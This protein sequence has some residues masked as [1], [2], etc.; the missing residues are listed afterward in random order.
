MTID[1]QI[2]NTALLNFLK[3]IT[4][5]F[6][7]ITHHWAIHRNAL[8]ATV[9]ERELYEARTD[10]YLSGNS[11]SSIRALVE[12]KAAVRSKKVDEIFMQESAQMVAW[13]LNQPEEYLKMPGRYVRCSS[14]LQY[15]ELTDE[16]FFQV[17]QDRHEIYLNFA[18]FGDKYVQYL[19]DEGVQLRD[20]DPES[21]MTIFEV[22]PYKTRD[23]D[24][25]MEL[26]RILLALT[27]RADE[28]EANR[29]QR[30][31]QRGLQRNLI[32]EFQRVDL[33]AH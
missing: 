29:R 10:G 17:L 18:Q 6:S 31:P 28:D 23:K 14:Y 13:I 5:S 25:M 24:H 9:N 12:V 8:H 26:G 19:R 7:D 15:T 27:L 3:A 21:F 1:E 32:E 30:E 33:N 22:G 20:D 11:G 2:V 4:E 16:R